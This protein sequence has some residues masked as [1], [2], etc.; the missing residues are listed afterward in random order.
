MRGLNEIRVS[1]AAAAMAQASVALAALEDLPQ[2]K[3]NLDRGFG[4]LYGVVGFCIAAVAAWLILGLLGGKGDLK[5]K[6]I[7]LLLAAGLYVGLGVFLQ[8]IGI[9]MPGIGFLT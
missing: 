3:Q 9:T 2:V 5:E 1:A 8:R 6:F 7:G 4:W